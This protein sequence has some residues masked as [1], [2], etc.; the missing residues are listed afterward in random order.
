MIKLA[1]DLGSWVTKI[2]MA[3][4]GV[5][6][7]EATCAAV[8]Q[9]AG[10]ESY[11]V[12]FLGNKAR[13]LSGKAARDTHIVNPVVDG[14]I[15]HEDLVAH[16]LA[17][18]LGKLEITPRKARRTEILFII[19]CGSKAALK[20]KY[21]RLAD[22]CGIGKVRFTQ[23][24][25]AAILGANV[26]LSEATPV[27]C[28]DIGYALT[29]IAAFS[30]DGIISGMSINLGGGNIDV[31]LMDLL[32]E[33]YNLR[34]GALT[35][36]RLKNTVA[37]F[38]TGDNKMAAIDGRDATSGKPASIAITTEQIR[39]VLALYVDKIL[40]YVTLTI[41]QLPAE[42][43]SS[44]MHTGIY[45]SGGLA[46]TDGLAGYISEKLGFPVNITEEPQLTSVIGGGMILSSSHYY[47]RA[48][49]TN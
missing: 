38:I 36:E 13:A 11:S 27:F 10:S 32:A 31:H 17:F 44:V 40:E 26:P 25:F 47:E 5:V 7:S 18:F 16:L 48:S 6:L 23:L 14:D 8:E 19:P 39:E 33:N 4:C 24:P 43:A 45:L 1:I 42:V 35:A 34:V 3:G 12:K 21:L 22:C 9:Q 2:Y 30:L 41:S 37:S 29:N 15:V 28:V 49:T 20:E 46:K